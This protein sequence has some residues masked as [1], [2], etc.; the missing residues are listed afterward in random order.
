MKNNRCGPHVGRGDPQQRSGSRGD[1]PVMCGVR[2]DP[3]RML[4]SRGDPPLLKWKL[5]DPPDVKNRL[6]YPF[7][8]ELI[9]RIIGCKN[10]PYGRGVTKNEQFINGQ[11][12]MRKQL[13][14]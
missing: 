1:P 12:S 9:F 7:E 2:G 3:P 10:R 13:N 4:T 14:I 11:L 5:G 8:T 6:N